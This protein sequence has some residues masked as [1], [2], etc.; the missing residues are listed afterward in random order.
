[1]HAC[2]HVQGQQ[3]LG[4]PWN[5][6][7]ASCGWSKLAPGIRVHTYAHATSACNTPPSATYPSPLAPQKRQSGRLAASR[8][9]YRFQAL[10]ALTMHASPAQSAAEAGQGTAQH[11]RS[12]ALAPWG[13]SHQLLRS[14]TYVIRLPC[15]K[16]CGGALQR[17]AGHDNVR[18]PRTA[19]SLPPSAP[20]ACPAASK[21]KAL[22]VAQQLPPNKAARSPARKR[23]RPSSRL[24]RCEVQLLALGRPCTAPWTDACMDVWVGALTWAQYA[25]MRCP[26]ARAQAFGQ[27]THIIALHTYA[28]GG[29]RVGLANRV[30]N[31]TRVHVC[32]RPLRACC[33][34][35]RYACSSAAQ[36][37]IPTTPLG[38]QAPPRAPTHPPAAPPLMLMLWPP[39]L[40][41]RF[42][43]PP[44][45]ALALAAASVAAP[46]AQPAGACKARARGGRVRH[47]SC[48]RA[49][50]C[51]CEPPSP[52]P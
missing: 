2:V 20:P 4:R 45:L 49:E 42:T 12:T 3:C 36:G 37:G 41:V 8:V 27:R 34:S 31:N 33:C 26:A 38:V 29:A 18:L 40:S 44:A 6:D 46:E 1:M 35:R 13:G 32:S 9:A 51:G 5:V 10:R 43:P 52:I 23:L 25:A 48:N 7:S 22:G 15:S 28:A 19:P 16:T 11:T 50:A 21:G 30:H 47:R 17:A 14:A 39:W 24:R